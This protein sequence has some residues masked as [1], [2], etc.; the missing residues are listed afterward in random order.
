MNKLDYI[1]LNLRNIR[2]E[3]NLKQNELADKCCVSA[4]T[5]KCIECGKRYPSVDLLIAFSEVLNVTVDE[6]VSPPRMTEEE[7]FCRHIAGMIS[8]AENR[9]TIFMFI[10][11]LSGLVMKYFGN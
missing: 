5:I 11:E 9:E 1:G 8:G 4:E 3:N 7:N 10:E 6:I 2:L